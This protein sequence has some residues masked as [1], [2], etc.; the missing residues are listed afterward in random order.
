MS[1]LLIEVSQVSQ[2]SPTF[3]KPMLTGPDQLVVLGYD[4]PF[5]PA[6]S[7]QDPEL[8]HLMVTEANAVLNFQPSHQDL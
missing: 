2:A 5:C 4:P 8:R 1:D 7:S 6:S 3:Y